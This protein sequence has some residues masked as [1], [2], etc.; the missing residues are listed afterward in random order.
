MTI[1]TR[2]VLHMNLTNKY[3]KSTIQITTKKSA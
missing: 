1:Y 2:V 3:L